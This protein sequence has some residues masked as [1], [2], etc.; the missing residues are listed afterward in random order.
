MIS[1][2]YHKWP[3]SIILFFFVCFNWVIISSTEGRPSTTPIKVDYIRIC[4]THFFWVSPY[5]PVDQCLIAMSHIEQYRPVFLPLSRHL[6]VFSQHLQYRHGN[7]I[8]HPACLVQVVPKTILSKGFHLSTLVFGSTQ[9]LDI[10]VQVMGLLHVEH[11]SRLN[12]YIA[13]SFFLQITYASE[14]YF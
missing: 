14:K 9:C 3:D 11:M 12:Y 6:Q 13:I 4:I 10:A 5:I 7:C 2:G 8:Y 1:G